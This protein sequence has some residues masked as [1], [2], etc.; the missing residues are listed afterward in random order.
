MI[1]EVL[2]LFFFVAPPLMGNC[3]LTDEVVNCQTSLDNHMV[4]LTYVYSIDGGPP[5][6]C[7]ILLYFLI[8]II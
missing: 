3:E 5:R 7:I 1:I 2:L 6:P 8:I 4:T